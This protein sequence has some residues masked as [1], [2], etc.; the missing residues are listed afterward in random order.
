MRLPWNYEMVHTLALDRSD[1]IACLIR[2]EQNPN[3]KS[4]AFRGSGR[5]SVEFRAIRIIVLM[6]PVR[7][8]G[9]SV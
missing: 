2:G 3:S 5:R 8:N 7:V 1:R 6:W 9:P 4:G